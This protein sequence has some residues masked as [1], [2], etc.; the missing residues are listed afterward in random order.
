[1]AHKLKIELAYSE[2]K[3]YRTVIVPENFNFHQLHLVIQLIMNWDDSH[4]YQFNLGAPYRSDAVRLIDID[5][6]F[7]ND[8]DD[9]F[10]SGYTDFDSSKTLISD[11]FNGQLKKVNYI[12]DFGDDWIHIIKPLKKPNEEVL[13]PVCIKGEN[14]APIDD[15]GGIPGF[16]DLLEI[17]NK[18]RKNAEERDMLEWYGIPKGKSY[19]DLFGFDIDAINQNLASIFGA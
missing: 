5:D 13:F 7:D 1:M 19:N 17:I 4:I 12:Y 16:Y 3:I 10:G 11:Y 15:I 9:F 18:K 14:A 2:P 8:F 6:D